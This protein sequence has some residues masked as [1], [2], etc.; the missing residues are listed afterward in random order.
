MAGEQDA[1]RARR[2]RVPGGATGRGR[3]V[4]HRGG[5]RA[6][7]GDP[8]ALAGAR[9]GARGAVGD[10]ARQRLPPA[11]GRGAGSDP[12]RG[13]AS[14][15]PSSSCPSCASRSRTR[16][17]RAWRCWPRSRASRRP[18]GA[19]RA[20]RFAAWARALTEEA[21][22][23]E[24][25]E[26]LERLAGA[27]GD[28]RGLAAVYEERMEATFDAG[29]QRSLAVRLAELQEDQLGDSAR[30]ADF[31]RKALSLPGDEADVLASLDRVLRKLA[32]PTSWPRSS[33]ARPRSPTIPP[34][35]PTSWRRSATPG[36]AR[37]T[38]PRAR[39]SRIRDALER[40]AE[41]RGRAPRAARAARSRPTRAR[42][43]S[44]SSSRSP[45]R[46]ATTASWSRS[47]SI[48]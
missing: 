20:R 26:A 5:D 33:R 4:R 42:A 3:A 21:T 44:R 28:Y 40:V 35:R 22:E 23:A 41:H 43:R 45:T 1:G 36:C 19:I 30:A 32:R 15:T 48:G 37:S 8:G 24:P 39:W 6:L 38:T 46:A 31:L 47:T 18:S 11:G 13:G 12:A 25:R 7:P 2:A 9:R 16:W 27:S 14:G 17:R 10:R 29:L 34:S